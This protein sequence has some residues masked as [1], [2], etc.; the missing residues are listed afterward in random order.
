MVGMQ[1]VLGFPP[2]EGLVTNPDAFPPLDK[3]HH[4]PPQLRID[5]NPVLRKHVHMLAE[6]VRLQGHLAFQRLRDFVQH[7]LHVQMQRGA[8]VVRQ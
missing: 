8:F 5:P 6:P 2:V 7:R 4:A 3:T 1:A